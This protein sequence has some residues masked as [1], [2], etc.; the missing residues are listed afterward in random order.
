MK[1]LLVLVLAAIC[2][3]CA[4]IPPPDGWEPPKQK[5]CYKKINGVCYTREEFRAFVCRN[6]GCPAF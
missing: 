1:C 6:L 5:E 2:S 3:S 4:G